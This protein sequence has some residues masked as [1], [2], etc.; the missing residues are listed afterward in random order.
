M[1]GTVQKR[2][3][4]HLILIK[5]THYDDDGYPITWLRSHIPSNTLA[6]LY[7]LGED[8]RQR[9]V[10][11]AD[12]DIL[13]QAVRRD[14]YPGAARPHR[15]R[16]PPQRRQGAD[17]P[18]RRAVQPV[19]ARRRPR[20]PLPQGRPAGGDGR[21]PCRRLPVDAAGRA[22]RDPGG[23][24][25]GHLDLRR[26][27]RG[28]PSRHRPEGRLER[29]AEAALQLHG[30]PAGHRGCADAAPAAGR[31]G[32]QR[33]P[34]VELRPRPRLPVP[35]LV[36]HHHQRA[37]PQEPLPQSPTISKRSSAR[38]TSRAS[39][40]SSSPTT[41]WPATSTGKTSSTG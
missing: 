18:G 24:G 14:Q 38:T 36:L 25:H 8:C 13:H 28:R 3:N 26:R 1:G 7:G 37:G 33:G 21:L 39:R 5:P 17:L 10:L 31:A 15:G 2:T 22:A 11:G 34:Q 4:F 27:G 6:A 19:P 12:V 29:H 32:A 9:Q 35:V 23:H 16:H 30:R 40:R 41:T 20:P